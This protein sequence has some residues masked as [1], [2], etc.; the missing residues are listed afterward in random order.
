M[1]L[2]CSK[3]EVAEQG[4]SVDSAADSGRSALPDG[5]GYGGRGMELKVG[6]GGYK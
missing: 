1:N 3:T 6:W 4:D 5:G 2:I